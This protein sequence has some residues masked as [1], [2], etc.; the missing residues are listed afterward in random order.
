LYCLSKG[1]NERGNQLFIKGGETHLQGAIQR[2][3]EEKKERGT[4]Y[5]AGKG[6]KPRKSNVKKEVVRVGLQKEK[7]NK[8]WNGR[9]LTKGRGIR[10]SA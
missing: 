10:G 1:E 9:R 2:M 3:G 7:K 4:Y 6:G 8:I 5:L